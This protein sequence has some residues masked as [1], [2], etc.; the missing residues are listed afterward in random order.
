MA[1]APDISVVIATR[2]R[3]DSL[4]ETLEYLGRADRDGLDVEVVVVDNGSADATRPTVEAFAGRLPVRYLFEG[5]PGKSHALNRALDEG[6]LGEVVAFLDDDMSPDRD[7]FRGVWAL[8]A[9]HPD[10]DFFT[11]RSY[12]VWPPG[13]P[14]GWARRESIRDWAFSVIDF[15]R[16]E[17]R[18]IPLWPSGNHFWIRSRVL[19]NGRRF[20]DLWFTEPQFTLGLAEEGRLGVMGPDAVAGHRIQPDLF[21]EKVV[22]ERAIRTGRAIAAVQLAHRS[23][24]PQAAFFKDHAGLCRLLWAANVLRW[25]VQYGLA[26]LHPSRDTRFERGLLALLG[27]HTNLERLRIARRVGKSGSPR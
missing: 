2:D 19:A 24:A 7:W 22:R 8:C 27:L 26:Q 15:E 11:G 23:A 3:A 6:G 17:D 1:G 18:P 4:A 25:W 16:R 20:E 21:S 12:V 13:E 9:R 14:P 5:Q 10:H